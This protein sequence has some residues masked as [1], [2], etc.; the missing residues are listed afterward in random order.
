MP[1]TAGGFAMQSACQAVASIKKSQGF[2][3]NP[4]LDLS[5]FPSGQQL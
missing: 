3:F 5:F 4:N 2:K 1:H